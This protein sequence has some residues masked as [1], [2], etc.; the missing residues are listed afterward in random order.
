MKERSH[1]EPVR[2]SR[3]LTELENWFEEV[4]TERRSIP[5]A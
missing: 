1:A 3:M 2:V 4:E 5:E